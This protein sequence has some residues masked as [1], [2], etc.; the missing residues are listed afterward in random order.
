M[1]LDEFLITL[2]KWFITVNNLINIALNVK[3]MDLIQ[4]DN[5][6]G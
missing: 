1:N 4:D 2:K 3:M 5:I 6:F